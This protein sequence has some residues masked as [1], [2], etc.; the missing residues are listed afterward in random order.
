MGAHAVKPTEVP[1]RTAY[2]PAEARALLSVSMPTLYKAINSGKLR[3]FKVGT[4][5][6]ISH[7]AL[8]DFIATSEKE[9]A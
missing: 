4:A 9:C 7:K 3:S 5:R 8:H 1:E 6:R 2:S